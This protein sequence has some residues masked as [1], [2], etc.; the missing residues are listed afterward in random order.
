MKKS[1]LVVFLLQILVIVF[2]GKTIDANLQPPTQFVNRET[3]L[4]VKVDTPEHT[5]TSF[6]NL[7]QLGGYQGAFNLLTKA[8]QKD[9]ENYENL[10]FA[11]KNLKLKTA[12]FAKVFP[13]VTEGNLALVGFVRLNRFDGKNEIAILG[14]EVLFK[15]GNQWQI[16]KSPM[17]MG[18]FKKTME[19]AVKTDKFLATQ[20]GAEFTDDQQKQIARQIGAMAAFHNMALYD[21]KKAEEEAKKTKSKKK[22][23]RE[24]VYGKVYPEENTPKPSNP[25]GYED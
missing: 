7:L 2:V 14:I 12:E 1:L 22:S 23:A 5:V 17:T 13:A 6:Y 3:G 15:E 19:L 16:V 10:E 11:E 8:T 9:I 4:I 21:I 24:A 25:H 18:Q 20:N